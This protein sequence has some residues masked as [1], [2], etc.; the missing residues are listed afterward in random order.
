MDELDPIKVHA[1][2]IKMYFYYSFKLQKH[3]KHYVMKSNYPLT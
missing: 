3:V 2:H 1:V